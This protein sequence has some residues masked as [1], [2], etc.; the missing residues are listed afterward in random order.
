MTY[1]SEL[2]RSLVTFSDELKCAEVVPV[3]KKKN[4]KYK[5]NYTPASILS[6]ISKIYERCMH[7]QT[8]ECFESLLPMFQ[9][10][11]RQAFSAH[12][13]F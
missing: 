1:H 10:D 5:N 8:S 6:N 13:A 7:K 12:T 9:C 4:E 11:F 2:T 3:Y